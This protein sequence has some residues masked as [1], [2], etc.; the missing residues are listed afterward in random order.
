MKN[1]SDTVI[2]LGQLVLRFGKTNRGTLYEDGTTPESDTDHTVMLGLVACAYAEQAAPHLDKGKIAQFALV[3]DLVEAYAGDTLTLKHMTEADKKEKT[4]RESAALEHIRKEIGT[5]L[6]WVHQTIEE[7]ESLAT[8]EARFVKMMD[9]SM[10][11]I[12]HILNG[13]VAIYKQGYTLET[14]KPLREK[15]HKDWVTTYAHDQPEALKLFD[16]LADKVHS[17]LH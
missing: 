6:P 9:K 4:E 1:I 14:L 5:A 2:R 12:T 8:P 10:P 3:H 11:S 15:H 7:Y 16:E 13:G 17:T